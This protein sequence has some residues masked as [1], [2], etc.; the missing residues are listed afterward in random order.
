[1]R[2]RSTM[3]R[4]RRAQVREEALQMASLARTR[5]R[6]ADQVQKELL[7]AFPGELQMGEARMY[8]AGW[9][10]RTIRE[11]LVALTK[12]DGQDAS[13]VGDGDVWRWLRGEIYPRDWLVRLCKLFRCHQADLGWPAR[14][15]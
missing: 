11:G 10:V 8:A 4:A 6:T 14:G 13:H 15:N 12:E 3:S 9:T 1:M 5:G 7:S 2:R